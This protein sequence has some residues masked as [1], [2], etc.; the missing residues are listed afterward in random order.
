MIDINSIPLHARFVQGKGNIVSDMGGEKVM[1]NI[2]NGK[3]YNL[4]SIGGSI[5]DLT[6]TPISASELVA[7]LTAEYDV[8]QTE[9]EE[10]VM[11]FLKLLSDQGLIHIE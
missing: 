11:S 4:G 6:V 9:C 5:W 8:D 3:Y 10:H 7:A 1:M 2:A